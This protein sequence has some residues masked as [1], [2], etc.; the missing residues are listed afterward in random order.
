MNHH[1]CWN[2][3]NYK[4]LHDKIC[5]VFFCQYV[6]ILSYVYVQNGEE[7]VFQSWKFFFLFTSH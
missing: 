3:E 1:Y 6:F 5:L 4:L 7:S 2:E